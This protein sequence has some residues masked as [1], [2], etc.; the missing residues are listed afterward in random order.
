M[1]KKNWYI[2][3]ICLGIGL[4]L[5]PRISRGQIVIQLPEANI[6]SGLEYES[7]VG[8]GAYSSLISVAPTIRVK[9]NSPTFNSVT[10]AGDIPLNLV[11]IQ[12]LKVNGIILVNGTS[13]VPLSTAYQTVYGALA[14]ITSGPIISNFRVL[15]NSQTWKAGIYSTPIEFEA[16][17]IL[18]RGG[19]DPKT[20]NLDIL[21]PAFL[22]P[23]SSVTDQVLR[24]NDLSYFRTTTGISGQTNLNFS[25]SVPLLPK[26]RTAQAQFNFST[27]LPYNQMPVVDVSQVRVALL[28]SNGPEGLPL[29]AQDLLLSS[30]AG[31]AVPTR[32]TRPLQYTYSIDASTL[33]AHFLQAGTYSVP[34]NYSWEKP[35]DVYPIGPLK[36]E[37]TA[38]LSVEVSDL[39]ELIANQLQVSLSFDEAADYQTGVAQQMPDHLRISKTTPYTV[40]VRALESDF[41]NGGEFIPLDVLEIGPMNGESGVNTLR[42]STTAQPLIEASDPVI[43]RYVD[44]QYRIPAEETRQLLGKPAG[45]YTA[46]IVF[47][48]VAP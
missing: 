35:V 46:D 38:N 24:V 28:N 21:V 39:G 44:L 9:A 41:G 1:Q 17:A 4:S 22:T 3:L 27:S 31:L 19:I 18:L 47:S 15:T 6:I 12:L 5:L 33:K 42:L 7:A 29:S 45:Q 16:S 48:F 2:S 30:A 37:Q 13:E 40:Y 26:I 23:Q 11:Y 25:A 32:N 34:L 43:D 8:T 14:N 10:G 20:Q 36:V